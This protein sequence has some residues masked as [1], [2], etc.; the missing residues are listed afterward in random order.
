MNS[1]AR[2]DRTI[3]R[4]MIAVGLATFVT[5]VV[6]AIAAAAHADSTPVGALPKGPVSTIRTSPKQLVAVALPHAAE[7]SG[8]SWRLARRYDTHVVRQLS[9]ADVGATVVIVFRVVGSGNTSLVFALTRGDTSAKAIKAVTQ[10][11]RSL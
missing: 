6:L 1:T 7:Q 11:I 3:A 2:P 8:L 5:G 10:K 4:S 9:E